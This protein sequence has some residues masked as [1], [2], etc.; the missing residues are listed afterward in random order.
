MLTNHFR[1]LHHERMMGHIQSSLMES[2][3]FQTNVK[4]FDFFSQQT[5]I[6]QDKNQDCFVCKKRIMD[7]KLFIYFHGNYYHLN[8][9]SNAPAC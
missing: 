8:C 3:H 7:P 6:F 4:S 9:F 5:P 1:S 2:L